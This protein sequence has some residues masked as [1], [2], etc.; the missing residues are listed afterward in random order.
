M[1]PDN[2]SLD[3]VYNVKM[4]DITDI[5]DNALQ[6]GYT[7]TWATDVSE[8]YFS[9]KNGVAF[10]PEKDWEDMEEEEQKE[11]FNGPKADRKI[12]SKMRQEAFD[13][14]ATTDDHGMHIVGTAKDQTGKEYYIVKNSWGEKNDYKGYIYVTKPY[15]KYKTTAFLLHKNAIPKDIRQKLALK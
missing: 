7:V 15:V 10:V 13:N 12:T 8:K 4:G 5:I 3:Q 9:W 14:Y 6:N 2:W 11:L 1:V